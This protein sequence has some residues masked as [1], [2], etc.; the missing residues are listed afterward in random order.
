MISF[1]IPTL[2][3][4]KTIEKTLQCIAGYT[5]EHEVIVSDGKSKDST[6]EIA[7]KYGAKVVMYDMPER[8]TIAMARNSGV[9]AATGEFVVFMDADVT[10]SD[11]NKFFEKANSVFTARPNVVALTV[12]Y[13]VLPELKTVADA[14]FFKLLCLDFL[15][16]NNVFH[17][18]A[19]AGEFQMIRREAFNKVGGFNEK[20]AA[21]EDMDLFRRLSKIGRT[22]FEKS[23]KIYHT[24]RRAHTIGWPKLLSEWF[25]NTVSMILFKRSASKE[26]KEIR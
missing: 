2:N 20:L 26:W 14:V 6:V 25:A 3:E 9:E 13:E 23:L 8:Q 1:I 17:I 5:G 24:G 7:K 10:I 18:G 15:I 19:S 16:S 4:E 22:H 11:I 21:A 12:F